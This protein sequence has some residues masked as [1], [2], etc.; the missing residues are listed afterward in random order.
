MYVPPAGVHDRD[1]ADW[2]SYALLLSGAFV[3]TA[4]ACREDGSQER[5]G[6]GASVW[7]KESDHASDSSM[8]VQSP[9]PEDR[10]LVRDEI[11]GRA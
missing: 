5:T 3:R 9:E 7:R 2:P 8:F 10:A 6:D 4:A 11:V 1:K